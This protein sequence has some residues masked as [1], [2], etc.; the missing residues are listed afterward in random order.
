MEYN[1]SKFEITVKNLPLFPREIPLFLKNIYTIKGVKD[2]NLDEGINL[3]Q[4]S[5]IEIIDLLI[6]K[7]LSSDRLNILGIDYYIIGGKAINNIIKLKYLSKLFDFDIFVKNVADIETLCRLTT[8]HCYEELKLSHNKM[9]RYQIYKKLLLLNLVDET[10]KNYYMTENTDLIFYGNRHF[11]ENPI[12]KTSGVFIKLK[13]RN[14]LFKY[15]GQDINYTNYLGTNLLRDDLVNAGVDNNILYIPIATILLDTADTFDITAFTTPESIYN[16]PFE[17]IKYV[18]FSFILFF[19]LLCITLTRTKIELNIKKLIMLNKPLY[20]NCNMYYTYDSLEKFKTM[21]QKIIPSL[22]NYKDTHIYDERSLI[23]QK[24]ID[25]NMILDVDQR[26]TIGSF[27]ENLVN[28]IINTQNFYE[29]NCIVV[30][31]ETS[32]LEE[33]KIFLDGVD[34]LEQERLLGESYKV[35]KDLDKDKQYVKQYTYRLYRDLNIYCNY[36]FNNIPTD[37]YQDRNYDDIIA[38]INNIYTLY[39][40]DSRIYQIKRKLKPYFYIYSSQLITN[41]TQMDK[42]ANRSFID[43]SY[44]KQGDIIQINQYLSGT[45][46]SKFDFS[47][48]VKNTPSNRIFFKIKINKFYTNWIILNE[49]SEIP[50]ES[51]ILLKQ[52]SIFFIESIDYQVVDIDGIKKEYKIITL[53]LCDVNYYQGNQMYDLITLKLLKL[54]GFNKFDNILKAP[55]FIKSLKHVYDTYFTIP[56]KESHLCKHFSIEAEMEVTIVDNMGNSSQVIIYKYNHALA[57]TVRVACWIQLLYLQDRLYNELDITIFDQ[58]FLMK[59][60]IASLFMISGRESEAGFDTKVSKTTLKVDCPDIEPNAYQ[61]YLAESANNFEKYIKLLAEVDV[62]LDIEKDQPSI[63]DVINVVELIED[64]PLIFSEFDPKGRMVFSTPDSKKAEF[65]VNLRTLDLHGFGKLTFVYRDIE[66]D[67]ELKDYKYCLEYYYYINN[68]TEHDIKPSP[69]PITNDTQ[70]RKNKRKKIAKYFTIA[71]NHDLIRCS[72]NSIN[73]KTMLPPTHSSYDKELTINAK[74]VYDIVKNTGDRIYSKQL[75]KGRNTQDLITKY[76]DEDLFYLCSTNPEY[77]ITNVLNTTDTYFNQLIYA[78]E[79]KEASLENKNEFKL[80]EIRSIGD[81]DSQMPLQY[82]GTNSKIVKSPPRSLIFDNNGNDME[83]INLQV[84]NS[85]LGSTFYMSNKSY[86]DII[87]NTEIT[88]LFL[89]NG[90]YCQNI[91]TSFNKSID[92][93]QN[94][95]FQELGPRQISEYE[96]ILYPQYFYRTKPFTNEEKIKYFTTYEDEILKK[97]DTQLIKLS[98][99]TFSKLKDSK[100]YDNTDPE[101]VMDFRSK[102]LKYK[103]KYIELKNKLNL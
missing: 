51:E 68:D 86:N 27:I 37:T 22:D 91:Y 77:C 41:F 71:H 13:L 75:K 90:I 30:L 31:G 67:L 103:K 24:I 64:I 20:Y 59:T 50:Q 34:T 25:D 45:F 11:R 60:C 17:N 4:F 80:D 19:L 100:I 72:G 58:K 55:L 57:H 33:N 69:G 61:R 89:K 88:N 93:E 16:N 8:N 63:E 18:D 43:L 7:S 47:F 74:L 3:I 66:H 98:K 94:I 85:N 54:Y 82:G 12:F 83:S 102:Y 32:V 9:L 49:Y 62:V 36:I 46:N 6:K 81:T 99:E 40:Q 28:K 92:D 95:P 56:Y 65:L 87:T 10:L 15:N 84:N 48:F 97:N 78:L 38:T 1:D 23:I 53:E 70:E 2:I 29:Q 5:L 14:D 52:N 44:I 42:L 21:Y 96:K 79:E 35:I 76:Y 101:S 26:T 73:V 39:H